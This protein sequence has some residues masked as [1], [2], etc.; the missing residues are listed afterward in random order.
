MATP[1]IKKNRI[2][3]QNKSLLQELVDGHKA[4]QNGEEPTNTT[5]T[6]P[7][8]PKNIVAHQICTLQYKIGQQM[9]FAEQTVWKKSTVKD[10]RA[11]NTAGYK[12]LL[13]KLLERVERR[14]AELHPDILEVADEVPKAIASVFQPAVLRRIATALNAAA[15]SAES[16]PEQEV[17]VLSSRPVK[18]AR[19]RRPSRSPLR[20]VWWCQWTPS[21]VGLLCARALV[22]RRVE[23]VLASHDSAETSSVDTNGLE[24]G[25]G[26][27]KVLRDSPGLEQR[28]CSHG[29]SGAR[30]D[31][32]DLV[33]H[34]RRD[35]RKPERASADPSL[36]DTPGMDLTVRAWY[37]AA[38]P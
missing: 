32:G 24:R 18:R 5:T 25:H 8:A 21:V 16:G 37:V 12:A 20:C 11:S 10:V 28:W 7:N 4:L 15:D 9:D 13:T 2:D 26:R 35:L 36:M 14:A 19:T 29:H 3:S 31:S 1:E 6:S 22:P 27:T 38:N 17:T 30:S 23:V 33:H 34:S